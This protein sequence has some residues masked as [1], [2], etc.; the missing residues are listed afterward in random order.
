VTAPVRPAPPKE[1]A[2]AIPDFPLPEEPKEDIVP[3][4]EKPAV[5]EP[6][7]EPPVE[8]DPYLHKPT[9]QSIKIKFDDYV[10]RK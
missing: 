3:V 4:Q 10:R 9:E 6:A 8:D 5:E 7:P 1:K 2:D